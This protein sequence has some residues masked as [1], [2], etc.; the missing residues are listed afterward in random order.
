MSSTDST[1]ETVNPKGHASLKQAVFQVAAQDR[2]SK[3]W[4][5]IKNAATIHQC[6]DIVM[7]QTVK[8]DE[9][10]ANINIVEGENTATKLLIQHYNS[11]TSNHRK[12]NMHICIRLTIFLKNPLHSWEIIREW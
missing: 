12:N 5:V 6:K 10:R 11:D 7:H 3:Q 8:K 1:T 9:F 4:T 2:K